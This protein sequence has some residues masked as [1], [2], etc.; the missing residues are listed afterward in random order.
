MI[1]RELFDRRTLF[2]D[3]PLL[4]SDVIKAWAAEQGFDSTLD[5]EMH[6][7]VAFSKQPVAWDRFSPQRNRLTVRGGER[8]VQQLGD[9][10]AVVLMFP[11]KTLQGRWQEFCDGG[12][13]WDWDSYQPHITISYNGKELDLDGIKP[14]RGDLVFGP[15][16][17]HPVDDDWNDK[18]QE[19]PLKEPT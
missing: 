10:G 4:N 14:Y 7:T 9:K 1:L 16:R 11:S 5:D 6:V 8:V 13:S 19:E 12:A 17:F 15:E 18:I 2:V 3:R